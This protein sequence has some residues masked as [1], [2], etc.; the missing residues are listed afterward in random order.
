MESP[1]TVLEPLRSFL[2]HVYAQPRA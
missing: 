1:E 2:D